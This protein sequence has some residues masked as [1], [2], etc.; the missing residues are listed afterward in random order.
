[1]GCAGV[2]RK[3]TVYALFEAG[4]QVLLRERLYLE[5]RTGA[6]G[7]STPSSRAIFARREVNASGEFRIPF[8]PDL[9]VGH[10]IALGDFESMTQS[11]PIRLR[12]ERTAIL[13]TRCGGCLRGR[14]NSEFLAA[15]QDRFGTEEDFVELDVDPLLPPSPT[16]RVEFAGQKVQIDANGRFLLRAIPPGSDLQLDV[17]SNFLAMTRV[18]VAPLLAGEER[19]LDVTLQPGGTLSGRVVD[20]EGTPIPEVTVEARLGGDSLGFNMQEARRTETD[21]DGRFTLNAVAAGEVT[22]IAEKE[23]W[24]E[25]SS[26][27]PLAEASEGEQAEDDPKERPTLFALEVGEEIHGI[28]LVLDAGASIEGLVHLE[29]GSPVSGATVRVSFDR[30]ALSDGTA[31]NA[32]YG[33]SGRTVTDE[34][35]RFRVRGLG[36]G[37]FTVAASIEDPAGSR[38][39][40][41]S[42]SGTDAEDFGPSGL[43]E[44][45]RLHWKARLDAVPPGSTDLELTLQPPSVLRGRVE[46]EGG[47]PV[48]K[49][50]VHAQRIEEGALG[51][52]GQPELRSPFQTEE[53]KFEFLGLGPGTWKLSIDAAEYALPDTQI[54]RIPRAKQTEELLFRLKRGATVS[55]FVR[56]P[57]GL[58]CPEAEVRTE[59][60]RN[61]AMNEIEGLPR[62]LVARTGADGSFRLDGLQPGSIALEA[63][64]LGYAASLPV[65]LDLAPGE[66]RRSV[67]F[68]LRT[69]GSIEGRIFEDDGSP[70]AHRVVSLT[71]S[72]FK[73][74]QTHR[75]DAEGRFRVD[76]LEPGTWQISCILSDVDLAGAARRGDT[77]GTRAAQGKLFASLRMTSAEV[78]DG[79]TTEV[80]LGT[81]PRSPCPHLW[82]RYAGRRS[83]LPRNDHLR[84]RGGRTSRRDETRS[85]FQGRKLRGSSDSRGALRP[86]GRAVE[87]RRGRSKLA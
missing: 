33:G 28:V 80:V 10:L 8:P 61:A 62:E 16:T 3:L 50:V 82:T 27:T 78:L 4:D 23:G 60:S 45:L 9:E 43:A 38:A 25:V 48:R 22:L 81:P 73:D 11:E 85:R 39:A 51:A 40:T 31:L 66:H 42:T 2:D 37:P 65:E 63:S 53:G 26:P 55:G 30:A 68:V 84:S 7:Q 17:H 79:Q 19:D 24:L 6:E 59:G 21:L 58:S 76:S 86:L 54:V 77:E 71:F 83:L 18:N 57:I 29:D 87:G 52:L 67:E 35:G 69:G 75:S 5:S 44:R 34:A 1:G 47:E 32:A 72:K 36:R 49:F 20:G 64:A 56:N 14:V 74:T 70:A 41:E 12:L 15:G 46:D 13:A